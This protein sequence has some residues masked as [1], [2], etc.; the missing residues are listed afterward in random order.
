[1]PERDGSNGTA[2]GSRKRCAQPSDYLADIPK[3][4]DCVAHWGAWYEMC[5]D[6]QRWFVDYWKEKVQTAIRRNR[7]A[8]NVVDRGS[9]DRDPGTREYGAL[10]LNMPVSTDLNTRDHF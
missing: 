5:T 9:D 4:P 10:A 3:P 2:R 7:A 6:E 1:M 8:F